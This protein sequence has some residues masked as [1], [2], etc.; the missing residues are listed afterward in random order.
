MKVWFVEP[1][2]DISRSAKSAVSIGCSKEH[3]A[4]ARE[5]LGELPGHE[6]IF[7]WRRIRD[8]GPKPKYEQMFA[9]APDSTMHIQEIFDCLRSAMGAYIC[10]KGNKP[11][12]R[13][14]SDQ[15]GAVDVKS[16][17]SEY[18]ELLAW[19][20]R[21]SC[22]LAKNQNTLQWRIV[23]KAGTGERGALAAACIKYH[24]Y[25]ETVILTNARIR[26]V[27]NDQ[28]RYFRNFIRACGSDTILL[29]PGISDVERSCSI[30]RKAIRFTI[31]ELLGDINVKEAENKLE[32][33]GGETT[34]IS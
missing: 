25:H 31:E 26:I 5:L 22:C 17:E 10:R 1:G 18:D 29:T 23:D 4:S 2:S 8:E 13:Q 28:Q 34:V 32:L 11:K 19:R 21:V 14:S 9:L 16:Y 24:P 33:F 27:T 20:Y 15:P 30:V 6:K 12:L 7:S 3:V